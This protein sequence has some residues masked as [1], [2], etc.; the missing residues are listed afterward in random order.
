MGTP[1]I[2]ST[3]NLIKNT[4]GFENMY[5]IFFGVYTV[6][7]ETPWGYNPNLQWYS[8]NSNVYIKEDCPKTTNSFTC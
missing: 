1:K 2:D 3:V 7:K 8:L 4:H 6:D 5:P